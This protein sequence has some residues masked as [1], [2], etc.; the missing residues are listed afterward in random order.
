M[1]RSDDLTF[2]IRRRDHILLVG[3]ICPSEI[4]VDADSR[5]YLVFAFVDFELSTI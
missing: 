4:S 1:L 3:G 5:E 2:D